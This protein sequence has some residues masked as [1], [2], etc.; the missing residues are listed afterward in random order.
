VK[1]SWWPDW[2]EWIAQH[3]GGTRKAPARLGNRRY[4][5]REPAPGRYVKQRINVL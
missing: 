2:T 5:T 1:G 3:G 4:R